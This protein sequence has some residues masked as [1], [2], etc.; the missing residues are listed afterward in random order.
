MTFLEFESLWL[1]I[2]GDLPTYARW[3]QTGAIPIVYGIF[4]AIILLLFIWIIFAL[5][6]SAIQSISDS[7]NHSLPLE[8]T[9]ITNKVTNKYTNKIKGVKRK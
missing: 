8:K 9:T 4:W 2:V 7:V 5:P 6:I 1:D 3:I